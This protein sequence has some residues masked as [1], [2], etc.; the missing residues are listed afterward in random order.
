MTMIISGTD[1]ITFN[2]AS[3]QASAG[4]VL[5]VVQG[6]TTTLVSTT[7]ATYIA[8]N[9]TA[10]ITPKFAT[11]KI[12]IFVSGITYNGTAAGQT[13]LK[14]YKNS[15]DLGFIF[16]QIYSPTAGLE[17]QGNFSYIDSPA[18]T[19]STVYTVYL[20]NTTSIGTS[21]FPNSGIATIILMEIAG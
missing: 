20:A 10:T 6:T 7:A 17:A 14:L 12:A 21:A 9:V 19:S 1:G 13:T 18:T 16:S 3:T 5:Q 11:S 15:A 2:N 8:T 4:V